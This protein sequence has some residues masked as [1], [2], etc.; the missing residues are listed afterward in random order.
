MGSD[1]KKLIIMLAVI[2]IVAIAVFTSLIIIGSES[3]EREAAI[4]ILK[5]IS[6]EACKHKDIDVSILEKKEDGYVVFVTIW[7]DGHLGEE[8]FERVKAFIRN[9]A[10]VKEI[11]IAELFIMEMPTI[12]TENIERANKKKDYYIP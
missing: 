8:G 11:G 4:S 7:R 12:N 3:T 2:G 10:R 5:Q 9:R 6:V 1:T